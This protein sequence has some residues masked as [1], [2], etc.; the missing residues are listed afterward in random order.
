WLEDTADDPVL[1]YELGTEFRV[2]RGREVR[3]DEIIE[4]RVEVE[5]QAAQNRTVR[6]RLGDRLAVRFR[7]AKDA[8]LWPAHKQWQ[9][10][11]DAVVAQEDAVSFAYSGRW[12]LI[13]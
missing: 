2:N 6:W 7:W 12:A 8:P 10:L 4:W 9:G 11:R 13:E 5:N 3:A 1:Q